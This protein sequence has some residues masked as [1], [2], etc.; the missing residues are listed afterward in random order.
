SSTNQLERARTLLLEAIKEADPAEVFDTVVNPSELT[1][2]AP[3]AAKLGMFDQ[4]A[5]KIDTVRHLKG[6]LSFHLDTTVRLSEAH[7]FED[8]VAQARLAAKALTG[9]GP[10]KSTLE[11][12]RHITDLALIATVLFRGGAIEDSQRIATTALEQSKTRGFAGEEFIHALA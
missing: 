5:K 4:L 11:V 3:V 1:S 8:A 9:P 12:E 2:I 6:R 10:Q 7:F